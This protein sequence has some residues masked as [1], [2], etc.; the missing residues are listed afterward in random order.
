ME[1]TLKRPLD[2]GYALFELMFIWPITVITSFFAAIGTLFASIPWLFVLFVIGLIS[3]PWVFYHDTIIEEV[4]FT[5]RCRVY[6]FYRVF[7]RPFLRLGQVLFNVVICPY[8]GLNWWTYGLM[9]QHIFPALYELDILPLFE[10]LFDL[11]LAIL[12]D[13]LL[14]YFLNGRFAW[15]FMD[16]TRIFAAWTA[17]WTEWQGLVCYLCQDLCGFWRAQPLFNPI[18]FLISGTIKG[19]NAVTSLFAKVEE[20]ITQVEPPVTEVEMPFSIWDYP[21]VGW[22]INF[23][24][25]LGSDALIDPDLLCAVEQAFNAI[26]AVVHI[27]RKFLLQILGGDPIDRP[28]GFPF[29]VRLCG[30]FECWMRAFENSLQR[31]W[32]AFDP[33]TW[34][35]HEM[36]CLVDVVVCILAFSADIILDMLIHIDQV[37]TY[38]ADPYYRDVIKP[39]VARV[40][41]M[42]GTPSKVDCAGLSCCGANPTYPGQQPDLA[43][44]NCYWA[45]ENDQQSVMYD[46]TRGRPYRRLSDCICIFIERLLCDQAATGQCFNPSI[47]G[48]FS[49]CCLTT[50]ILDLVA[51]VLAGL[52]EFTL[53]VYSAERL[54]RFIDGQKYTY[55][56][57]VNLVKLVDCIFSVF[58]LIPTV[59]NCL[60]IIFVR[61]IALVLCL[62]EIMLRY[63][64]GL[65]ALPYYL[66]NDLPNF[67]TT[68]A[69]GALEEWE[70]ILDGFSSVNDPTSFSNCFCFVLNFGAPIP[71]IPCPTCTPQGYLEPPP[72]A[73]ISLTP[74]G[75][76]SEVMRLIDQ[77]PSFAFYGQ[78]E[79]L[80]RLTPI[81]RYAPELE[82]A[83]PVELRDMLRANAP[84]VQNM[85]RKNMARFN[86]QMDRAHH[87]M[88][89]Q[90]KRS[91][92]SGLSPTK[93]PLSQPCTPDIPCFDLCCLFRS[94]AE[95]LAFALKWF[96]RIWTSLIQAGETNFV[97][98]TEGGFEADLSTAIRLVV[99]PFVCVC[100][101]LN[102]VIPVTMFAERPDFCCLLVRIADLVACVIQ[103]LINSIKSLAMGRDEGFTYFREGEFLHDIDVNLDITFDI[104]QCACNLVRAV[105]PFASANGFD[106][107]CIPETAIAVVIELLRWFFQLVINLA[108]ISG[109]D[110][111]AYFQ[112]Q[113]PATQS[114][115]ELPFVVQLD[116]L[117]D[118]AFGTRFQQSEEQQQATEGFGFEP[119][120]P[121][122]CQQP[123]GGFG[124]CVCNILDTIIPARPDPKEPVSE[125][126]C[127][128][129]NLCCITTNLFLGVADGGKFAVRLIATLWQPWEENSK[130]RLYPKLFFDFAF[131]DENAAPMSPEWTASCGK[132]DPF[133]D[134]LISILAVCPCEFLQYVDVF[135]QL[136]L[137]RWD[138]FC[139][140][141]SVQFDPNDESV[142]ANAQGLL[143]KAGLLLREIIRLVLQVFL[144]RFG[145]PMFWRPD[146]MSTVQPTMSVTAR[147]LAPLFNAICELVLALTCP[148]DSIIFWVDCSFLRER[149]FASIIG[150]ALE[151]IIR[152]LELVEGFAE[153]L[154]SFGP[155]R[156]EDVNNYG[157]A[158]SGSEVGDSQEGQN[159]FQ[160][161]TAAL[162]N[163]ILNI[164]MFPIDALIADSFVD[165]LPETRAS[166]PLAE[167]PEGQPVDGLIM[168]A[169]RYIQCILGPQ[170]GVIF[171]PLIVFVS[172]V[173]QL[174]GPI[175]YFLASVVIFLFSLIFAVFGDCQCYAV[176][177]DPDND[178]TEV[179]P[180]NPGEDRKPC[181]HTKQR[182]ALCYVPCL[183]PDRNVIPRR[184]PIDTGEGTPFTSGCRGF[185][186]DPLPLCSATGIIS[187]FF[188]MVKSFFGIFSTPLQIP[189]PA[190]MARW[191]T[192]MPRMT[193]LEEMYE[194]N[195]TI[196][197]GD[198]IADAFWGVD[199]RGCI[200]NITACVCDHW[201]PGSFEG[202]LWCA[203]QTHT[204]AEITHYLSDYYH[205]QMESADLMT[206]C[207][208]VIC[209]CDTRTWEEI[210]PA[211]RVEYVDCLTKRIQG[212]RMHEMVPSFPADFYY[213][214]DGVTRF[215]HNLVGSARGSISDA[216]EYTRE[217]LRAW[218]ERV[219]R[220]TPEQRDDWV[221]R[222]RYFDYLARRQGVPARSWV[223]GHL[224][225]LDRLEYRWRTG[226]LATTFYAAKQNLETGN[227][228]M[229]PNV[230][231]RMVATAAGNLGHNLVNSINYRELTQSA[232]RATQE[233]RSLYT[234]S[235][236]GGPF[237]WARAAYERAHLED[238][239]R[240][241]RSERKREQFRTW[242]RLNPIYQWITSETPTTSWNVFA[243][244]RPFMDHMSNVVSYHRTHADQV[245][246]SFYNMDL[247]L[248]AIKPLKPHGQPPPQWTERKARNW[249]LLERFSWRLQRF[250][251]PESTRI[252]H[253]EHERF[254]TESNCLVADAVADVTERVATHCIERF[255]ENL[256]ITSRFL[257]ERRATET[258]AQ[259]KYSYHRHAHNVEWTPIP[260]G[261]ESW[262]PFA[263]TA[264]RHRR[265]NLAHSTTESVRL[266]DLPY[267]EWRRLLS[268]RRQGQRN[269]A[270]GGSFLGRWDF[271][272]WF[273]C[274]VEDLTGT[275]YS[276]TVAQF[277]LDLQAW[278]Q[279][280]NLDP[281]AGEVGAAY[282]LRFPLVCEWPDNI[283]CSLGVGLEQALYDVGLWSLIIFGV[284]S[285]LLPGVFFPVIALGGTV[286]FVAV[287]GAHAWRWSPR[288]ALPTPSFYAGI[289]GSLD[290]ESQI[291]GTSA[292]AALSRG[293]NW[294]IPIIT[295]AFPVLPECL[296][297]EFLA[298]LDKY[299]SNCYAF[300]ED[301]PLWWLLPMF[302]VNGPICPECPQ[303]ID[304]QNCADI[305]IGNGVT[306]V[307]YLLNMWFPNL[308]GFLI[309]LADT[310]VSRYFPSVYMYVVDT[311]DWFKSVN[312]T[313]DARFQ[314][315]FYATI[316][317]IALLLGVGFIVGVIIAFVVLVF[318][319]F[320]R[321]LWRTFIT[322]PL[323]WCCGAC[324]RRRDDD[325]AD[326]AP[327][328]SAPP[329]S[330]R[331]LI[332]SSPS[333]YYRPS[334]V[335]RTLHWADRA[336]KRATKRKTE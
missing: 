193:V 37:V 115:D 265:V 180:M 118:T 283:D 253:P 38:P 201:P 173:W 237:E 328:P 285:I 164:V 329:E 268:A 336:I 83:H 276:M 100:D 179:A 80:A 23:F 324:C 296:A 255:V 14:G 6:D 219:A 133:I 289:F 222:G 293:A 313:Q 264:W 177:D 304:F 278:V 175:I 154:A 241:E 110:G 131:C 320:I 114:I 130:G 261:E 225:R 224:R 105:F 139:G 56:L 331:P 318:V 281:Y 294:G 308:C 215:V 207:D 91:V 119:A 117:L 123:S 136:I 205:T 170:L 53:N 148:L 79:G 78:L 275:Q 116:R 178:W 44:I 50:A 282:W 1:E 108:L 48:D 210:D 166:I 279:N 39:K 254:L 152:T 236:S 32:D 107:C 101:L 321:A 11:V 146:P 262:S 121:P 30:A 311:F 24:A 330:P 67:V 309:Q 68:P 64:I 191:G 10:G 319:G 90:Q 270:F 269:S 160:V 302:M 161:N 84:Y 240:A 238:P 332:E 299:I 333:L 106:I 242:L 42:I 196:G 71:P 325:Y 51:D 63:I 151:L 228:H 40:I 47:V 298:L 87:R 43:D 227:W 36:F 172:I 18:P 27:A 216:D 314:W 155:G 206:S 292:L 122:V 124:Y 250:L 59:G 104:V 189:S 144:R 186:R 88:G 288:C 127:P 113:N 243:G 297:D 70:A 291:P 202:R 163:A 95:L 77:D 266:D 137:P 197:V 125:E 19:V 17:V 199:T 29:W 73:T 174:L 239:A 171:Y 92:T 185:P 26:M 235:A 233:A 273:L 97:Y 55:Y 140:G 305:G 159:P 246:A 223:M 142:L 244:I 230:M 109:A 3:I 49:F 16:F 132:L 57:K 168:A 251:W 260:E 200:T 62:V 5:M 45:D 74:P 9:D 25:F 128:Y 301:T 306:N 167:C 129:V 231:L 317:S 135:L 198:V 277:F 156:P 111:E 226:E 295:V 247:K 76:F 15:E 326:M 258:T 145:N 194:H 58:S 162:A 221:N 102:L 153:F 271:F 94:L 75:S 54:F 303:R 209:S 310:C 134:S 33:F 72:N 203:N 245:P 169:L 252:N 280:D 34:V 256:N 149:F 300:L 147:I 220:M 96:G 214:S 69:R 98:W 183:D 192:T 4:E 35:F 82:R 93:P 7:I 89:A 157:S 335:T 184:C 21:L 190:P 85:M 323:F 217:R 322:S 248:R 286:V 312:E 66:V 274:F 182:G 138:C 150:W 120:P 188:Q 229:E 20:P 158:Q 315:C 272:D 99:E 257:E 31:V 211:T 52:F 263:R 60:R 232:Y 81:K 12:E 327:E 267:R 8:N 61:L 208:E 287:T 2:F 46:L 141:E 65:F 112:L 334:V 22:P 213:R 86:A 212:E 204:T 284:L 41:N 181:E 13:L 176:D 165:P 126:N 28:D 290:E 187:S 143:P 316:T 103:T 307:I 234:G 195:Q 218:R 249:E 259:R